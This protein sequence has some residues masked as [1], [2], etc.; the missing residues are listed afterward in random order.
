MGL[1]G[2]GDRRG[3][4]RHA[5]RRGALPRLTPR[6]CRRGR[7]EV[8]GRSDHTGGS[9]HGYRGQL[10]AGPAVRRG[11]L[12]PGRPGRGGRV[13]DP[14]RDDP[15]AAGRGRRRHESVRRHIPRRVPRLALHARGTG[16]R[17]GPAAE[18]WTG[19]GTHR[20]AFQGIPPA[21]RKVAVPGVVF[22]RIA[23]GKIAEFCGSFN[24]PS[25]LRQLGATPAASAE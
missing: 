6:D 18:C 2:G 25:L 13:D 20:G 11:V 1:R 9:S 7:C 14:D 24:L 17:W 10:D 3:R 4:H 22:Y 16:R 19:R 21:G 12:E 8:A 5:G 15:R 23:G